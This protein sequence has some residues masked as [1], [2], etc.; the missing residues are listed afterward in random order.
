MRHRDRRTPSRTRCG[1]CVE[2]ARP[3][4]FACA[5]DDRS[6]RRPSDARAA[7]RP[8]DRRPRT[9]RGRRRCATRRIAARGCRVAVRRFRRAASR[10]TPRAVRVRRRTSISKPTPCDCGASAHRAAAAP[11]AAAKV[12]ITSGSSRGIPGAHGLDAMNTMVPTATGTPERDAP[13]VLPPGAMAGPWRVEHVLGRGGMGTVYAVV[14]DEIGKRAALKL[15]HQRLSTRHLNV[16]RMLLEAKVVNQVGHPNIVD[17]FET[18]ALADGRPYIVMERLT[19]MPLS[20]RVCATK[21]LPDQVI[22]I[23][24][25]ICDALVAAHAAGVI[26]RDLKLDNVFLVETEDGSP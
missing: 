5:S 14:H 10:A 24:R 23:L 1:T 11:G 26:H 4:R 16:D 25:Q 2:T 9:A 17:I 8:L 12:R 20:E 6:R 19:G 15:M 18:G 13:D 21:L 7:V 3:R 22:A